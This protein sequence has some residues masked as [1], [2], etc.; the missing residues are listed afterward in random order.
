MITLV[1]SVYRKTN[2]FVTTVGTV[3]PP[4]GKR[5]KYCP[6]LCRENQIQKCRFLKPITIL[7]NQYFLLLCST[8]SFADKQQI[9]FYN[10]WSNNRG[11]NTRSTTL[12][13]TPPM[14]LINIGQQCRTKLVYILIVISLDI[15]M[16]SFNNH[17]WFFFNFVPLA[18][19][20]CMLFNVSFHRFYGV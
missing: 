10:L 18:V 5:D 6:L 15:L 13:I 20:R 11:S 9:S 17:S 14:D 8:S 16:T 3:T 2:V 7:S 19:D 1:T 4:E 12:T